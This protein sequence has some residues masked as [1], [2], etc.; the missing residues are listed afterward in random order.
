M[1]EVD[2]LFFDLDGTLIDSKKDLAQSVQWLQRTLGQPVSTEDQVG[3]FV[4]DGV[5]MLVG[6]ALPALKGRALAAALERYK[7]YYR[8]HCLD[9]TRAYGS[10]SAT[11]SRF[12]GKKLAVITNKPIRASRHILEHLGLLR[13][14][15]LVVGGDSLPEKKPDPAPVRHALAA[16]RIT[17][18]RR[19]VMIGDG[20]ADVLAGRR[21][22]VW[23][24]G[25][26]SDI[27]RP[28]EMVAARPDFLMQSLKELSRHLR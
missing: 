5:A 23:T 26:L 1:I 17:D 19:A 20:P 2:A 10:V 28:R 12:R 16:L 8:R 24:G 27:G 6:R 21:A 9:H 13:H 7:R 11:L 18:P 22:R 14:F 15:A 25:V 4:G 3:S